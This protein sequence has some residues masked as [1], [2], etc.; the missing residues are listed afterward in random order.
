M[1]QER[2]PVDVG[3]EGT[4]L[5]KQ[6]REGKAIKG[7]VWWERENTHCQEMFKGCPMG[8]LA[9]V[10]ASVS[11]ERLGKTLLALYFFFS[12]SLYEFPLDKTLPFLFSDGKQAKNHG[13]HIKSLGYHKLKVA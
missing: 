1:V 4:D 13:V 11:C 10:E 5:H 3:S 2:F 12:L 9:A 8:S 6:R 7:K